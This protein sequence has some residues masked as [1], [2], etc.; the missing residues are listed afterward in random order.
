V[1]KQ[2]GADNFLFWRLARLTGLVRGKPSTGRGPN[3]RFGR[4]EA[5]LTRN[6]A[7][8]R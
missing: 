4:F 2:V 6:I 7:A 1:A 3:I 5:I 8:S